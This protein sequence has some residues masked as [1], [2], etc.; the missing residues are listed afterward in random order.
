LSLTN[1]SIGHKNEVFNFG[2][3]VQ[4]QK[5]DSSLLN[6]LSDK[7]GSDKGEVSS[8]LNPYPWPSHNYT[9]FYSLV[10]GLRRNEIKTVVECGIG[11][12]NP[13]LKSSMGVEGK[14]GASLRMWREYFPNANII[15]CDIDNNILFSEERVNTF[16]CD[17]TS[18]ESIKTFL[19]NAEII[20]GS[21]DIIIDDGL[22]EYY[23]GVCFFENIIASLRPDGIYI[24][25]DVTHQDIIKYKNYFYENN[26]AFEA[27]FVY[28]KSPLRTWGDDN[29]LICITRK[30]IL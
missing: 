22:H 1:N 23:A 11:T 25:E 6:T 17:Q 21:V 7:Y 26:A 9:D 20:E 30:T 24:I 3:N 19:S 27:R 16:H 10:F 13:A 15:G 28:L 29:N 14:P 18:P 5:N 12:N 8:N 2:F 4:Y